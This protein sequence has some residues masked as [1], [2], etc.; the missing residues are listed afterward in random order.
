MRNFSI[1]KNDFFRKDGFFKLLTGDSNIRK[2]IEED[3]SSQEIWLS[4]QPE[5]EHFKTIRKKYLLYPESLFK[6]GE[7]EKF[8]SWS[9]MTE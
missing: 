8:Q 2:M 4:F 6:I 1:N 3:K 9:L 5:V 7:I